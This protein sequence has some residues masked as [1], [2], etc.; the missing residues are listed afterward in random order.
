ML[1]G[2]KFQVVLPVAAIAMLMISAGAVGFSYWAIR[3]E[4]GVVNQQLE[5]KVNSLRAI[6][7]TTTQLMVDRAHASMLLL[8]DQ[9]NSRGG[10]DRGQTVAVGSS[11][12]NDILVGGRGQAGNFEIVDY[13]TRFHGGTA[14]LFTKDGPRFV[15][16][17]TN[18]KKADGSRAIGTELDRKNKAYAAVSHGEAY[19][20]VVDIL[21]NAYFTGYEP[22][23]AKSGEVVGLTYVGYKAELPVL[24]SALDKARLLDTGFVAIA[25]DQTVRYKPSWITAEQAQER[26]D[27]R[28]GSWVVNRTPLPEWGLTIVSAY[29]VA[30]LQALSLR[31]GYGVAL[32]G[33]LIGTVISLVLYLLL[34]RKVLHLL[35]GEPRVAAS[36]MKRI[37]DGDLAVEIGVQN[38]DSGSLMASLK[39]MQLKLKNLVSAVRGGAAEVSDQ[40]KKFEVAASVFQRTRDDSSAQ[41]L[42]KQTRA[43]GGTLAILEKS[44]GRF[45]I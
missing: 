9:I 43:V 23:L 4:E 15:R 26:I 1:K 14:T 28:D 3:H 35:G 36:Y 32:A 6:C 12:V 17:A 10:A 24:S 29:P 40:A 16:I 45:R 2:F 7:L 33:L 18:V 42:L 20:G 34:D 41:E 30:E 27:N 21:G 31:I 13:V 39:V 38:S 44:V 19:Y 22:L 5:D 37:A 11:T 8:I 25:D